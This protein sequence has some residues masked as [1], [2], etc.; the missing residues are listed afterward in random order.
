V[1]RDDPTVRLRPPYPIRYRAGFAQVWRELENDLG[2]RDMLAVVDTRV[3]ER[4]PAVA[5]WVRGRPHVRVAGGERAKTVR[6]W[7][8]LHRAAAEGGLGRDG[9]VVAIGG[10]RVGDLAGFFAATWRRGVDWCPVATTVLSL[11]DSATGGKT[12]INLGGIKNPVGAFHQ[13]MAVYGVTDALAT[14]PLRQRRSGLAEILKS[15]WIAAPRLFAALEAAPA[16]VGA[17]TAGEWLPWVREAA[18]V[19]ARIVARD[20]RE[21]GERAL[22]NF[23]HT[24][25]H[26][27]EATLRPR[28]THG[29]AVALGMVAAVHLSVWRNLTDPATAARLERALARFALPIRRGDIPVAATLDAV[30][31][32]KK[33][34][35]G[36][37][38]M[39]LT[40][41]LGVASFGHQ[42]ERR[43]LRRALQVLGSAPPR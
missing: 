2:S 33:S 12:A 24:L 36:R 8:R 1:T 42:I 41:G 20:P 35:G 18:R 26:A 15:A 23:G 43:E 25:G 22:L 28:P 3:V 17:W 7:E 21:S 5:R 4:H 27:L 30:V 6:Q 34:R 31:L 39:V 19:K 38:R 9:L 11:A 29:E 16:R 37:P 14:L 32:D 13:P 10:G 40:E